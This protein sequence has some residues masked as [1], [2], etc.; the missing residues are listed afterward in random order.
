MS[1][2]N[3]T[4]IPRDGGTWLSFHGIPSQI[5]ALGSETGKTY[6]L[7][8]GEAAPGDGAPPH[9][10]TFD[11]GFYV[12]R[13][14]MTFF[15]GDSSVR[16][17]E[18]DFI[19]IRGG[20]GHYTKNESGAPAELLTI[21]AP[22]GFDGFQFA[23]GKRASGKEGPFAPAA[24]DDFERMSAAAGQFG[25][26]LDPPKSLFEKTPEMLV[27]KRGEGRRVAAAGDV[28]TFLATSADTGG[29]YALW[30]A[31]VHPAAGAPP[32]T[33]RR[34]EEGFFILVGELTLFA[35]G[36]R[37]TASAGDWVMLPR[38]IKHGF[39][40][41]TTSPVQMLILIAPAGLDAM[42]LETGVPWSDPMVAPPPIG[43]KEIQKIMEVAP[44]Y[45]IE[46]GA[47]NAHEQH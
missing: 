46:L 4:I 7:S 29:N 34:E 39:K 31:V 1:A 40:N 21:C 13:G 33:H 27:R 14:E 28:Y 45:G 3:P 44:R 47:P 18:G 6:T 5:I 35:D 12:L 8:R 24:D 30:H 37:L 26:D 43:S 32:H 10:H 19:N 42:F 2:R 16:L 11:E 15:A 22:S 20:T 17:S 23:S 25:I 41:E 38:D 36:K 9:S